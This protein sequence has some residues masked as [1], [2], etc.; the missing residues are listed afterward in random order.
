MDVAGFCGFVGQDSRPVDQRLKPAVIEDAAG[1]ERLFGADV[2]LCLDAA[3]APVKGLLGPAVRAFF[4]QGGKRCH[5]VGVP[6]PDC[7]HKAALADPLLLEATIGG[8]ANAL[9]GARQLEGLHA[10]ATVEE[11]SLLALPDAVLAG[12]TEEEQPTPPAPLA[13]TDPPP[14]SPSLFRMCDQPHLSKPRLALTAPGRLEWSAPGAPSFELQ[15]AEDPAWS[16]AKTVLAGPVNALLLPAVPTPR[17]ARVRARDGDRASIWSDGVLL[18]GTAHSLRREVP[19]HAFQ[20][21]YM[22]SLHRALLRLCAARGDAFALLSLPRH[23]NEAAAISHAKLLGDLKAIEAPALSFGALY[24]PWVA[25]AGQGEVAPDGPAC[26]AIARRT[27][28]RGAWLAP[29]GE[30]WPNAIALVPRALDA[31]RLD[32]LYQAGINVLRPTARGIMPL[33]AKTL[34]IDEDLRPIGVRRLLTLLR[35]IVLRDGLELIFEPNGEVLHR[36]LQRRFEALMAELFARG[37]FAPPRSADAFQVTVD[38][39][40]AERGQL[41]IELR[42][43]PSRPLAF[44]VVRLLRSGDRLTLEES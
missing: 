27:I 7:F 22:L 43:A 36:A 19:A 5:I 28:S 17:Y 38:P 8:V 15:L 32:A 41:A 6:V 3:G 33:A 2:T 26:G 13:S 12:W 23:Y 37:A 4:A 29:A 31:K 21:A 44:L 11:V 35:R 14:A 42:I 34:A 1:F 40:G 25:F 39:T 9:D 18:P 30:A 24:H 16:D 20:G 10:L